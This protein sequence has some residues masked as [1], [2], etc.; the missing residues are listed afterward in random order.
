MD[1]LNKTSLSDFILTGLTDV[2]WLQ[3][4]LFIF[5]LFFYQLGNM[6]NIIIIILAIRDPSLHS[7]MYFFLANLSFLDICFSSVTVP[8]IMAGFWIQ[9]VI[10]IKA[11]IV[12]MYFFH[13]LGFSEG[14][15]L[16]AMG[17]DRYVAICHPLRYRIIMRRSICFY[18]VFLSWSAGLTTSLVNALMT[19]QLPF[20]NV[21]RVR[22]FYC[23]VKPVIK[24]ACR[25][26]RFNEMTLLYFSGFICT[27][28]F[29]LTVLS[30]FYIISHLV[31]HQS[32]KG[33]S[34]AFS[35]CSAHLTV[36]LLF[37]GT[38]MCTYL[39]PDSEASIE[40]DRVAA[41]LATVITPSLNPIIYTLRNKEVRN[42]L[43]N[44]F[45]TSQY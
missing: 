2:P 30:Y 20:C 45:K 28:T 26:I 31:N 16:S 32:S 14:V 5:V 10:S 3:K 36:V 7:P 39:G 35:T 12:Q 8:K 22:H 24:L 29:I 42:S 11:C 18:L 4:L 21:N 37:Y 43:R 23:D 33:R 19:S 34:K 41:I 17:Y 1:P 25:D 40:S 13:A 38:A 27:G 9:N 6:G 15:L 44:M